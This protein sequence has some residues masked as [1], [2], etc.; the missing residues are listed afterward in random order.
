MKD[1]KYFTNNFVHYN[2]KC[3]TQFTHNNT[4]H[5]TLLYPILTLLKYEK[6]KVSTVLRSEIYKV[7]ILYLKAHSRS[8]IVFKEFIHT[9][10]GIN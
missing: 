5:Q 6:N 8:K 9:E 2:Y 3:T 4:L 10:M 1:L 7:N